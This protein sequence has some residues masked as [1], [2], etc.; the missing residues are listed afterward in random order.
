MGVNPGVVAELA[1]G[2][3]A[4]LSAN[5]RVAEEAA[6][7]LPAPKRVSLMPPKDAFNEAKKVE[8]AHRPDP[9]DTTTFTSTKKPAPVIPPVKKTMENFQKEADQE[10]AAKLGLD[11]KSEVGQLQSLHLQAENLS[12]LIQTH[13]GL[14]GLG[15]A[16]QQNI[17]SGLEVEH[18]KLLRQ[19]EKMEAAQRPKA[20]PI[21][22]AKE[23]M[24]TNKKKA[25]DV[26]AAKLGLDP[27]SE[28]GQLQSLHLQAENLSKLI[29]DR[30]NL[31]SIIGEAF[32]AEQQSAQAGLELEHAQLLGKIEK[33][34]AAQR[35]E[36]PPRPP[37]RDLGEGAPKQQ[38]T[39]AAANLSEQ[40]QPA[41][42]GATAARKQPTPLSP[43]KPKWSLFGFLFGRKPTT[44]VT[45]Q[46]TTNLLRREDGWL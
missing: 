12:K 14:R 28:V 24:A 44:P 25:D 13:Q 5:K 15:S 6:L 20:P 40:S 36:I 37:R 29:Q 42:A 4:V 35:T 8:T 33:M 17:Q 22:S 7:P 45:V 39:K 27:K 19:I 18:A 11:P 46:A 16:K 3:K 26:V 1:N 38:P 2:V 10:V 9:N 43:G 34:E 31:K 41:N 21:L 23:V 32:T 30:E